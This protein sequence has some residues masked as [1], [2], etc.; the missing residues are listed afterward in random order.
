MALCTT[1][2]RARCSAGER[3]MPV[4]GAV[5]KLGTRTLLWGCTASVHFLLLPLLAAACCCAALLPR[6]HQPAPPNIRCRCPKNTIA[7]KVLGGLKDRADPIDLPVY[8]VKVQGGKV[9][10]KFI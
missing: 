2:P 6:R 8:P 5:L 4:F 3:A 7:R 10:V 9:F 1:L